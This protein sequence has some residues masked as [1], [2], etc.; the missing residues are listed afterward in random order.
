[1]GGA[2]LSALRFTPC[3]KA[4]A[5][6]P[7]EP[8]SPSAPKSDRKNPYRNS[9]SRRLHADA[10]LARALRNI[11]AID[12]KLQIVLARQPRDEFLIR[13]RLRPAQL[14]IEMNNRKDNPEFAPQLQQQPQQRNRID[15]AGNANAHAIPSRQQF[16]PPNVEK[17]ALRQGMHGNMVPHD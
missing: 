9:A 8:P 10:I 4:G 16:L 5:S 13:V 2:A 12:I 6:A 17:H 1:M 3:K 14:V 15:P 11:V 7:E